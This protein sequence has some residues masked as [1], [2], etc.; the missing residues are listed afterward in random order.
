MVIRG[1]LLQDVKLRIGN[2]VKCP[3]TQHFLL[4][5]H[6]LLDSASWKVVVSLEAF[7]AQFSTLFEVFLSTSS[8]SPHKI[9]HEFRK[10]T[11]EQYTLSASLKAFPCISARKP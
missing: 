1:Q 2:I 6:L 7:L 10:R 4:L 8:G 9:F 3:F 5:L 11:K